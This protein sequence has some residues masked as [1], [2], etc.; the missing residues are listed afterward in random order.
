MSTPTVHSETTTA[1][2]ANAPARPAEYPSARKISTILFVI[3]IVL[4][5]AFVAGWLP[6]TRTAMQVNADAKQ[7]VAR[8]PIVT[9]FPARP[10]PSDGELILPANIQ[11][12]TEAPILARADGYL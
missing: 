8:L 12:V 6:R 5:A 4:G 7:D 1:P 3:V 11:A 10:A 2:N 9:V